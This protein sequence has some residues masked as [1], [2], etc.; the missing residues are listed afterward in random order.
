MKLKAA[1][2]Q[3]EVD[4]APRHLRLK[5]HLAEA[6]ARLALAPPGLLPRLGLADAHPDEDRQQ[7]R[8]RPEEEQAAPAGPRRDDEEGERGEHVADRIALLQHARPEAA[9]LDRDLVVATATCVF[10]VPNSSA[11]SVMI[12]MI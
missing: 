2:Q 7:R 5:E 1:H 8:D 10:V 6:D 12:P 4:E 11:T 3:D 9:L